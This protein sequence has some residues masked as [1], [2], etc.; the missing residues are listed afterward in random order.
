MAKL[1][2]GSGIPLYTQV[3]DEINNKIRDGEYITGNRIPPENQL[4]DIFGVSRITIRRAIRKLIDGGILYTKQGK[5]TFVLSSKIKRRLPKLYSFSDD[6]R[7]LGLVPSSKILVQQVEE[8]DMELVDLLQLPADDTSVNRIHR[9]R[10]ANQEPILIE[11]TWVPHFLCPELLKDSF[12]EMSLYGVLTEKYHLD[13]FRAEETYEVRSL[14][15]DEWK[16]LQCGRNQ[17][18]FL[19]QRVAFRQDGTPIELTRSVGR[20]DRLRFS[21]QLVT[22]EERFSRDIVNIEKD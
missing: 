16:S 17:P 13:L 21:V 1:I 6:M 11:Q 2:E 22:Q 3:V 14:K 7:G 4:C 8:A 12:E 18:A 5:G 10:F 19:I 15:P 20:G 9:I